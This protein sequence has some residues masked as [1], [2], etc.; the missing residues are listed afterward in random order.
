MERDDYDHLEV[1]VWQ[2]TDRFRGKGLGVGG[3]RAYISLRVDLDVAGGVKDYTEALY[4]AYEEA[5]VLWRV[6]G[7]SALAEDYKLNIN[8]WARLDRS[9]FSV[10]PPPRRAGDLRPAVDGATVVSLFTGAYG[11]DLG[12]EAAGYRVALGLDVSGASYENFRANRPKTPFI[13]G[14]IAGYST[15]DMLKEAGLGPGEVDVVT[16]GPPCQPFSTAGRREGLKDYRSRALVEFMRFIKEARPKAFVMEE[17]T[18]ILSSKLRP[19]DPPGSMW[20]AV[21]AALQE[22]GY[23]ITWGVLNAADFGAPQWRERVI[24]VGARPDTGVAPTLPQPTHSRRPMAGATSPWITAAEAIMGV[25]E[26][27]GYVD[28]PPKYAKYIRYVPGGGNWRQI[29][30]ELKPEAMNG[31]YSAGGGRMGF[32]R[33]LA[34]FEPSP[35]LM[36]SPIM[37]A[38]MLIHPWFD[39]PLGVREYMRLQG[40]PDDWKVVVGTQEAYELFGEAVPVP[41]AYAIAVHIAALLGRVLTASRP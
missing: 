10:T 4:S 24:V 14:D 17:V 25:N 15:A 12:F 32:Y 2:F 1:K 5:L 41:L 9:S 28:L 40:F 23:R 6:G 11:L 34:W 29:P 30:D 7:S 36:T 39:R 19:E 8:K 3:V 35:T 31:A 22:T 13:H 38:T 20:R 27:V 18:G 33:R 37:K 26:D 21:L 16:G